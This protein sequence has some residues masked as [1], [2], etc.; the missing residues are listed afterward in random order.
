LRNQ[1]STQC[2]PNDGHSAISVATGQRLKPPI[3][4]ASNRPTAS[5]MSPVRSRVVRSGSR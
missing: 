5:A 4:P 2:P 3:R 1:S